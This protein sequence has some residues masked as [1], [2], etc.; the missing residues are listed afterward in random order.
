MRRDMDMSAA[1]CNG[2]V[3]INSLKGISLGSHQEQV[4]IWLSR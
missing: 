4:S 1:V 2:G 3:G